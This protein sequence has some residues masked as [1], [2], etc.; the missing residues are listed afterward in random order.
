MMGML[1]AARK[2]RGVIST[3]SFI[4]LKR[5]DRCLWQALNAVGNAVAFAEAAAVCAHYRAERQAGLPLRRP[6]AF[7]ASRSL[8]QDYLDLENPRNSRR[9]AA[10]AKRRPVGRN[11]AEAAAGSLFRT[12]ATGGA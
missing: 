7:Q 12:D 10:A 2:D 4:W 5:E 1:Q 8:V 11:L 3:A 6:S 9:R